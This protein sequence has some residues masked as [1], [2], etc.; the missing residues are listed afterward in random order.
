LLRYICRYASAAA[1]DDIADAT[2]R[3]HTLMLAYADFI[4]LPY[5]ITPPYYDTQDDTPGAFD[6]S[7]VDTLRYALRY[8]S[9]LLDTPSG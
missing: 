2:L 5:A 7:Y 1:A 4:T 8:T 6:V 9:L 3:C